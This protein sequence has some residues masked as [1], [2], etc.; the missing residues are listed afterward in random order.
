MRQPASIFN[1]VI[2]PVMVGPSSSHTAASARIGYLL[3]C[4]CNNKPEQIT[5]EFSRTGSLAF[6][7]EGQ[8]TDMGLAGGLLG[9]SPEDERMPRAVALARQAGIKLKFVITDE[10]F[11]H[12]NTYKVCVQGGGR[13]FF[14]L[15]VSLGGGMIELQKLNGI[16]LSIDG[17]CYETIF[18]LNNC[19]EEAARQ[20]TQELSARLT[21]YEDI[22][23]LGNAAD[24]FMIDVKSAVA[25]NSK[26][27]DGAGIVPCDIPYLCPVAADLLIL[28]PV[29]PIQS[30]KRYTGLFNTAAEIEYLA[31]EKNLDLARLAL[32][33]EA[34]RGNIAEENVFER[35][36]YLLLV[37]GQAIQRAKS[38]PE[39]KDRILPPQ[40]YLLD[41][42]PQLPNRAL[43]MAIYNMTLLMEAKSAML[44]IVAAPTAGSCAVLPGVLIGAAQSLGKGE[45][46]M[47]KALLAASLVGV[48]IAEHASFAAEV[49]GCQAECG[50][51]SGM[52]A[53]GLVQLMG[54]NAKQAL[55]AAS[56]ALQNMF[57]LVCDPV[58][59]RVEVP[60]LGKNIMAGANALAMAQ[61]ALAG[62]DPVV[63]LDE[64]IAAFSEV[65]QKID[66]SLR[67]T[68]QGGL[69]LT[70]AAKEIE[71]KLKG[72]GSHKERDE[73]YNT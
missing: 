5:C 64:T 12:P 67:C 36:R 50:S 71:N 42:A 60:C 58:A 66:A 68:C 2:G 29:L 10:V 24:G 17:G 62:F 37:M 23:L 20:A 35:M 27:R 26:K 44:P 33:Y 13:R 30:Y 31:Q 38:R 19:G 56:L 39:Y 54:G 72:Y 46:E 16:P 32:L 15:F 59:A 8:G 45:D 22:I 18:L 3:R 70:P 7:H 47:V 21:G 55:N 4:M 73:K 51:A 40:A 48:L 25:V 57:G 11:L 14:A 9:L 65:G 61:T 52:A 34:R 1:D 69:S 41:T 6:C 63:P 28:P 49:G 53:A 43:N